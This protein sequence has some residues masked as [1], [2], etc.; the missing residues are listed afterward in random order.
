MPRVFLPAMWCVEDS[1]EVMFD[2]P[3]RTVAQLLDELGK[4]RP[5]LVDRFRDGD[6]LSASVSL[7]ID[8]DLAPRSLSTEVSPQSEVH[9]IPAI[10]GG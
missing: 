3:G 10:A 9:F 5:D 8:G 4:R 7:A 1:T 2:L 6:R